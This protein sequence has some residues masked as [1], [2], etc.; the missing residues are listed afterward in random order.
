AAAEPGAPVAPAGAPAAT[1]GAASS[2][3]EL[4]GVLTSSEMSTLDDREKE[5]KIRVLGEIDSE[6]GASEVAAAGSE[7]A[8]APAAAPQQA[9]D[10]GLPFTGADLA[11]VAIAGLAA[12]LAGI[13]IRRATRARRTA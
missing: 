13:A 2:A 8:A 12:L 5:G 11:F 9:S 3:A 6:R 4:T 10:E 1:A 7:E